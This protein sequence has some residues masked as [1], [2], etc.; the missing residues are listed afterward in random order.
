MAVF[1]WS[2]WAGLTDATSFM[3]VQRGLG[4]SKVAVPSVGGTINIISKATD[5]EKGGYLYAG[6]GNNA[7]SKVGF[8][9]SSGLND[10]GWAFT[11]KRFKNQRRWLRRWNTIFV[12]RIL[13]Q[14]C[15]KD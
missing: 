9:L 15:Q 7:Y 5:F 14:Y 10:N 1:F 3:Q 13:C 4:A 11:V 8:S 6:T 2:N 12:V